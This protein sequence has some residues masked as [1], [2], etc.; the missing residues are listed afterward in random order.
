MVRRVDGLRNSGVSGV[1]CVTVV[2]RDYRWVRHWVEAASAAC[3]QG[4]RRVLRCREGLPL[5]P[6]AHFVGLGG[7]GFAVGV[8][9]FTLRL[10]QQL[11][12]GCVTVARRV[13]GLLNGGPLGVSY[14]CR[15]PSGGMGV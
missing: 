9:R 2:C 7:G 3:L 10:S 15:C 8:G 1:G 4:L 13:D 11:R 5:L 12:V 14:I 6:V